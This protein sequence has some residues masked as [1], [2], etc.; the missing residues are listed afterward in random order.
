M[1]VSSGKPFNAHSSNCFCSR[2]AALYRVHR[3]KK[4][5]S[6]SIY[7]GL[8]FLSLAFS[9]LFMNPYPLIVIP[10]SLALNF[11]RTFTT[12]QKFGMGLSFQQIALASLRSHLSFS[13]FALFH[14]IR[15][16]LLMIIGLGIVWHPLWILG[17]LALIYTSIVDHFVKKP[18][19]IYPLFTFF[20]LSEHLA[21]QVGVFWGCL[22]ARYFGS[23]L[24]SF[25]MANIR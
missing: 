10:I 4:T 12:I 6:V 11:Q 18:G 23:Y 7:P 25:K 13:Y 20:C 22:K 5:F 2:S 15:Y 16:Y 14:L 19:L 3:D 1:T 21:Y 24:L 17:G 9:I 8:S